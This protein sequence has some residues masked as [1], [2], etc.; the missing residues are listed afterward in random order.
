MVERLSFSHQEL[1]LDEIAIYH[2]DVET[3]LFDFF[4]GTS[5]ALLDRYAD[6]GRE[7]AR[8]RSLA[9]L[10]YSSSL[11]VLSSVEAAVRL[12]YLRR[13]YDRWRDPLS[14]AMR[15]VYQ[16]KGSRAR[17][18]EELIYLWGDVA[19][20][21]KVLIS[22]L[23][24]AFQYRHWLAHGRYWTPKFGR[25]YDYVAVFIIAQNFICEMD[26]YNAAKR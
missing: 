11:A 26:A 3:A 18:E 20:L 25:Q 14:K 16:R 17:L 8:D 1:S 2:T 23:L 5:Q 10:D 24:G 21:P 19:A 7:E 22:G 12:D 13:A 6:V 9:E 4:S 15:K